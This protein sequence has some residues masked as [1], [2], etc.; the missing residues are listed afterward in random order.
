[1]LNVI[2]II[3]AFCSCTA[4]SA[5]VSLYY[6]DIQIYDSCALIRMVLR[7]SRIM[8]GFLIIM[9]LKFS[10]SFSLI[11]LPRCWLQRTARACIE[12]YGTVSHG[13]RK[14]VKIAMCRIQAHT[15]PR[16]Q[17]ILCIVG[18][19]CTCSPKKANLTGSHNTFRT[20]LLE[21]QAL[22]FCMVVHLRL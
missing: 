12:A 15:Q 7:F 8:H 20:A 18:K 6:L 11:S 10:S 5:E 22:G 1:M 2:P 21:L 14:L 19:I 13:R 9:F 17:R 3:A 16:L 4:V